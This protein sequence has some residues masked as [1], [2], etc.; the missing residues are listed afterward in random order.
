MKVFT[1][2]VIS[3]IV[4]FVFQTRK[5]TAQTYCNPLN[6]S[7][8]L[9]LDQPSTREIA[10][11][12]IVMYKDSYYLFASKSG[13][14]WYS[15]DLITWKF[16]TAT[17]LPLENDAPTAVVIGDWLYFFTSQSNTIFRSNDPASGKWELYNDSFPLSMISD[18]A[19]FADTDGR[20][21]CYYACSNSDGVMSRELDVNNK[22]NP[23]GVPV[24]CRRINPND[25]PL[26]KTGDHFS[27]ANTISVIGSWMNKYKGKYYYQ[28]VEHNTVFNSSSDVVY[29]S[30]SPI[31][32]FT[33][34]ANN[35]F[36]SKPGG[37][38][39]GASHGSTFADKYG[40]WWHVAA[41][42]TSENKA[43]VTR[44]GLFPVF[45][46]NDGYMVT[47][48][49]YGDYP[50][51]IP[52]HK[53]T[54]LS[55]I[56]PGW[57]LLSYNKPAEAS[58]SLAANP[59][60]FAFD[61]NIG[62]YWSAKTGNKNEWLSVDM[63][64]LCTINAV[65]VNFAEN[66]TRIKG[67]EGLGGHQYLIEYSA[68]KK[69]WEK[70]CD[71]TAN[72][73][74]LT[75]QYEVMNIPVQARYV[76]ITNDSVPDGNFAISGFRV[77]GKGTSPEPTKILMIQAVKDFHDPRNI[78][79]TWVKKENAT[80]FLIRYGTQKD[81]LHHSYQVYK[82]TPLT[83]RVPEKNKTYW[84]QIDSFGENGVTPSNFHFS[85]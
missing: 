21:Y 47:S 6:L 60:A 35:P 43:I 81:K 2:L 38:V 83:I 39:R 17:D 75:H 33:Y 22:L 54:H 85:R 78:K 26:K 76:K 65:Q 63:G 37:F 11:P 55:E 15:A 20:V 72:M 74:D 4:V 45:F 70:L 32:P 14:Y 52:D 19:V 57:A 36:S 71:K 8:R 24:D 69:N 59:I 40:N 82:N 25:P 41:M 49:D 64:S 68:D 50:I 56:N 48:T 66:N 7:Y 31:G 34:A 3:V 80:G 79:L 29:V 16:V 67:R 27:K 58:S 84:F 73:D 18:M 46:D 42:T 1:I 28:C 44:L 61:E 62:S 9:S 5:L 12:T 77:F 30:A 10:D 13:G 53:Y 23:K 51:I